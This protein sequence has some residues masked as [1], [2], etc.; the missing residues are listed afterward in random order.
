MFTRNVGRAV[1]LATL[2]AVTAAIPVVSAAQGTTGSSSATAGAPKGKMPQSPAAMQKMKPS[3]LYKMMDPD[4]KGYVTK[5]DFMKFQEKLFNTW[6]KDHVGR[7]AEPVF[8]DQ[9]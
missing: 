6:D 4:N 8:T 5:E 9:G 7:L 2:V 3:Q 1:T